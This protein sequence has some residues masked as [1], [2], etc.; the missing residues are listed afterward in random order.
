MDITIL[1]LPLISF[2]IAIFT[3]QAGISGAF[4]LLPFQ[5]SVLGFVSPAVSSTNLVYNIIAIPSGVYRY[6]REGRV[7]WPLALVII[8][9]T[10][11]GVF[12]GAIVRITYLPDP[13]VFKLFVGIVLLYL[14]LRLIYSLFR[15]DSKLKE[16]EDKFK[17]RIQEIK[18][19]QKKKVASG[20][21]PEAV[22]RVKEFHLSKI[23]YEFWGEEFSF[24]VIYLFF[25]SFVVGIIGGAYG[26]GGGAIIAPFLV[27]VFGLPAYTIAGSTLFAT[28][29]TSIIG[30]VYYSSLGFPP[31]WTIGVMIGAGGFFGMYF[32]A[33]FQKYMPERIIRV[34]LGMLIILLSLNYISKYFY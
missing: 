11:P 17:I 1:L 32:G 34:I 7:A 22:V 10:L 4:L 33:R 5:V 26:I 19:Q 20:I 14:G 16:I 29:V 13:K 2:V 9:G 23:S 12:I 3:A 25:L 27:A 8:L 6:F 21:P 31:N 15:Q 30:V 24:S 28:F 18:H